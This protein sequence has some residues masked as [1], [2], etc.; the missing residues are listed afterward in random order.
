MKNWLFLFS[1]YSNCSHVAMKV[2]KKLLKIYE[3]P[4][5]Q[6]IPLSVP[7]YNR[8]NT[9]YYLDSSTKFYWLSHC[10]VK[11]SWCPNANNISASN[12][13]LMH[14]DKQPSIFHHKNPFK[15]FPPFP[16]C[17]PFYQ[18]WFNESTSFCFRSTRIWGSTQI[19]I[20]NDI[21]FAFYLLFLFMHLILGLACC[22][23]SRIIT[24]ILTASGIVMKVR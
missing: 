4:G 14:C 13:W 21:L 9:Q 22:S 19:L 1:I 10:I 7:L 11:A 16:R 6:L 17:S 8:I 20:N 24:S 3:G 12:F 18:N 23:S 5:P 15:I 2:L